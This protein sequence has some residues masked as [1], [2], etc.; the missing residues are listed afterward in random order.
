VRRDR[1][2]HTRVVSDPLTTPALLLA[3]DHRARAVVTVERYADYLAALRAALP[4]CDGILASAK[5]LEDLAAAGDLGAG[6]STYLSINRTGLAGSVFELDD[7]LVASVSRAVA[8]GWTGVKHM[9]RI[10]R[11]DPATAPALELLGQ[12]VEEAR[13][14]GLEALIEALS[15]SRGTV[16]RSPDGVVL[17]AVIAH[18]RG[19]PL[20]KVAIPDVAPGSARVD[21]VARV[22]ASVGVP[23]LFLGGPK[24]PGSR[25]EVLDEIADTMAGGAAGLAVGRVIYQDPEPATMAKLVAEIVHGPAGPR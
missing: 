10:D 19:A 24:G 16:D 17:A 9:T 14:A 22:V 8:Q 23:V 13:L 6:Q 2:D 18:D 11:D 5:P 25:Q 4:S 7:R 12:V 21:A 3:A 20:L 1:P 15:W